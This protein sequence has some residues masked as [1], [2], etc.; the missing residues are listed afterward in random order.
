[1]SNSYLTCD[2][3]S[4]TLM[5][6]SRDPVMRRFCSAGEKSNASTVDVESSSLEYKTIQSESQKTELRSRLIHCIALFETQ[7]SGGSIYRSKG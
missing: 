2:E 3:R 1:M 7:D 5:R 4:Q 6:P